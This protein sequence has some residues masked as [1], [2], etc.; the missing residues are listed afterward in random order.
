MPVKVE[1]GFSSDMSLVGYL[2]R[3]YMN[4]WRA[5]SSGG[6]VSI[7]KYTLCMRRHSFQCYRVLSALTIG[8]MSCNHGY[9]ARRE[10]ESP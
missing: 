8:R 4:I 6:H 1:L 9:N 10:H 3:T 7:E 5:A 2:S